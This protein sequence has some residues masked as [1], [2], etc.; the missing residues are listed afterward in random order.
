MGRLIAIWLWFCLVVLCGLIAMGVIAY[1]IHAK[2]YGQGA[3]NPPEV[4]EWY[5]TLMQPDN[6]AVSC[7]G[8]ADAYYCEDLKVE[9]NGLQGPGNYCTIDDDRDNAVRHRVP[10]A[11]G[12]KIKI[13]DNKLLKIGQSN[14][15]GHGVVFLSPSMWV[16]CY[17]V[18]GGV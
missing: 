7:C 8:E 14:P 18:G 4:K 6:P 12:T 2:D 17:A 13:P 5:R 9:T 16:Y 10:I 1:P 3:D 15:T 11:N